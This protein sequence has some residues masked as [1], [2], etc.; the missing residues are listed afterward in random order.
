MRELREETG[1]EGQIIKLAGVHLRKTRIYGSVIVIGYAIRIFKENICINR[2]I[3]DAQFF[4]REKLPYIPFL[5]HR[6]ILEKVFE[7]T[8]VKI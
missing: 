7:D 6:K 2:E 8:L 3:K 4:S 1:L 5:A